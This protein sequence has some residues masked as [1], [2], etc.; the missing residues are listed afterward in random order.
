MKNAYMLSGKVV[1]QNCVCIVTAVLKMHAME[2]YEK[3]L[4]FPYFPLI[5]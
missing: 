3:F 4:P 1:G 2:V 5:F